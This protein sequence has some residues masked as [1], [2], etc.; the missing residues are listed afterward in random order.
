MRKQ[1]VCV[2]NHV[3]DFD[4]AAAPVQ[5]GVE[6]PWALGER[7]GNRGDHAH[8]ARVPEPADMRR[9]NVVDECAF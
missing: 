8:A 4:T 9:Y 1:R 5:G 3:A 7:V 6:N 2:G